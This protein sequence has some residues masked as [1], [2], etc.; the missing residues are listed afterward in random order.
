[1]RRTAA[2]D[3]AK[4]GR[5]HRQ[6]LPELGE[7]MVG[8]V[9]LVALLAAAALSFAVSGVSQAEQREARLLKGLFGERPVTLVACNES[10]FKTCVDAALKYCEVLNA[11]KASCWQDRQ[12]QCKTQS[13]C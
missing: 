3:A 13:G 4:H 9:R 8:S 6:R 2:P 1:M 5:Q 12:Q 7:M 11:D 10:Q